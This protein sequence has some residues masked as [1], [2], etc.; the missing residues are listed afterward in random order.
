MQKYYTNCLNDFL[1]I[2]EAISKKYILISKFLDISSHFLKEK[3]S[4]MI[5]ASNSYKNA[6]KLLDNRD[7]ENKNV[8]FTDNLVAILNADAILKDSLTQLNHSLQSYL[9]ANNN[10]NLLKLSTKILQMDNSIGVYLQNYN[11]NAT[12]YNTFKQSFPNNLVAQCIER[13]QSDTQIVRIPQSYL[14]TH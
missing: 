10:E 8:V 2:Y 14:S 4:V 6:L 13:F 12:M 5:L 1:Q 9:Q 11:K 7:L 3:D